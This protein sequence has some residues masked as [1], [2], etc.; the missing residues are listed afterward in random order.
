MRSSGLGRRTDDFLRSLCS[1]ISESLLKLTTRCEISRNIELALAIGDTDG[2]TDGDSDLERSLCPADVEAT[3]LIPLFTLVFLAVPRLVLSVGKSSP[4]REARPSLSAGDSPSTQCTLDRLECLLC[5]S[6]LWLRAVE[7][8][9]FKVGRRRLS[10][11]S[12]VVSMSSSGEK[13]LTLPGSSSSA[14]VVMIVG[15]RWRVVIGVVGPAVVEGTFSARP[16]DTA[17]ELC[18]SSDGD[19]VS[20]VP[21]MFSG[22]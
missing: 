6:C 9:V 13:I 17:A 21:S 3:L 12:G 14:G 19:R 8:D 16:I 20:L 7:C 5:L 4:S 22:G 1:T 10:S 15:L 18:D 11:V 2:D